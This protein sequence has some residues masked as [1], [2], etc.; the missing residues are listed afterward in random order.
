MA[1]GLTPQLRCHSEWFPS[2]FR[3]WNSYP[4]LPAQRAVTWNAL[5]CPL[6]HA[7]FSMSALPAMCACD[8][9]PATAACSVPSA[10]CLVRLFKQAAPTAVRQRIRSH[11]RS[12][13]GPSHDDGRPVVE[14]PRATHRRCGYVWG[15]SCRDVLR[16]HAVH[17]RG[18][19][20][21]WAQCAAQGRHPL[22]GDA[23][24]L[25]VA[26]WG[27]WR[28]YRI[29]RAWTPLVVGSVGAVSL[30]VGVIVVHGFPAMPMI[31]GGAILLIAA[32]VWNIVVRKRCPAEASS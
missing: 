13:G 2:K 18:S 22:A 27:Y 1:L 14:G 15:S 11:R 26:I 7:C 5:R 30:A 12:D 6:M 16:G 25:V 19:R 9:G 8:R 24:S 21:R 28:G 10:Q 23:G 3:A 29:H 31:Y 4:I 17:H 32:S 20:C